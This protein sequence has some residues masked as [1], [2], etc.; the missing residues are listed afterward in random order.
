MP[1][2][3]IAIAG[4]TAA[5]LAEYATIPIAFEVKA[6]FSAEARRD[7][8]FH[9]AEH[10]LTAPYLK[11]YDSFAPDR[12]QSWQGRF[13]TSQ[14]AVFLARDKDT[15]LGGA[16]VAWGTEGLDMLAGRRDL[17]VIWDI[18]VAPPARGRG[19]GQALFAAVEDWA[20]EHGCVELKVETQDVN[21]P[22]CRFYQA[23][24]CHLRSVHPRVY[25][26]SMN[27]VQFLWHKALSE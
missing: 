8:G 27:E 21:V 25:P 24:G 14:W 12:P 1:S 13:D 2:L 9:L 19:V 6:V 23:M 3:T 20:R 16:T 18:R 7:G 5:L 22:A 10:R 4:P 26:E 17:A 15:L 11:D